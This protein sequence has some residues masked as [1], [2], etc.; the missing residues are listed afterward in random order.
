MCSAT[1]GNGNSFGYILLMEEPLKHMKS[2]T[3][4]YVCFHHF[5]KV[6]PRVFS[7]L[8]VSCTLLYYKISEIEENGDFAPIYW[9]P[10]G[11]LIGGGD[12]DASDPGDL[13]HI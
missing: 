7:T 10:D 5:Q 1:A 8:S 6:N 13:D 4:Q 9:T 12:S 11:G 2:D 3:V